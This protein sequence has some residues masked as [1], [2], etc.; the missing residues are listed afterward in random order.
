MKLYGRVSTRTADRIFVGQGIIA[1][2]IFMLAIIGGV[3]ACITM[4][5]FGPREG[6]NILMYMYSGVIIVIG[7][8]LFLVCTKVLYRILKTVFGMFFQYMKN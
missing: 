1:L 2:G 6:T 7:S 3:I 4:A 8:M 5:I